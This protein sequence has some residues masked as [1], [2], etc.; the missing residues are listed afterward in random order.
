MKR[1][2]PPPDERL[3]EAAERLR[4]ERD[5]ERDAERAAK[6]LTQSAAAAA[7]TEQLPELP[8]PRVPGLEYPP[9]EPPNYSVMPPERMREE[10]FLRGRGTLYPG[11][12]P[13]LQNR[14][15]GYVPRWNQPP[16]PILLAGLRGLYD[17]SRRGTSYNVLDPSRYR[18]W[19]FTM[20]MNPDDEVTL[21]E[22]VPSVWYQVTTYKSL[23]G[24]ITVDDIVLSPV[25]V[26]EAGGWNVALFIRPFVHSYLY[27]ALCFL[28]GSGVL[29]QPSPRTH[30]RGIAAA[31]LTPMLTFYVHHFRLD[32]HDKY[33]EAVA[34]FWPVPFNPNG[35]GL[36]TPDVSITFAKSLQLMTRE[37]H[38]LVFRD[39][40]LFLAR[41]GDHYY[42]IQMPLRRFQ[43]GCVDAFVLQK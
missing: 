23:L 3:A 24:G 35:Y 31:L 42:A 2:A 25:S 43:E 8:P 7:A 10:A 20:A 22:I 26:R 1:S 29:S 37:Q 40:E 14:I 17:P 15:Y 34:P 12:P 21:V 18:T 36:V 32:Y 41:P 13:E 19:D 5:A 9:E 39:P 27:G 6:R 38:P 4:E 11:L 33:A 30:G 28:F 16:A